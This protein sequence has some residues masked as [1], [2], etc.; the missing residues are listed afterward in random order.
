MQQDSTFRLLGAIGGGWVGK[1]L[2]FFFSLNIFVFWNSFFQHQ[3]PVL[4]ATLAAKLHSAG[5]FSM[6]IKTWWATLPELSS[7]LKFSSNFKVISSLKQNLSVDNFEARLKRLRRDRVLYRAKE[8][9]RRWNFGST[10]SH[11]IRIVENPEVREQWTPFYSLGMVTPL[12]RPLTT[13]VPWDSVFF[14]LLHL[15]QPLLITLLLLVPQFL[16]LCTHITRE[17][18]LRPFYNAPHYHLDSKTF[19]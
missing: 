13:G 4:L 11:F 19:T 17:T 5:S 16:L 14:F 2:E 15:L 9:R 1:I 10:E 8:L 7:Q 18:S 6:K 12:E 3:G